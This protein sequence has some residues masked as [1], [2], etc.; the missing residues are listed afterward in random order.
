MS[1]TAVQLLQRTACPANLRPVKMAARLCE[2][3][4]AII[5][6]AY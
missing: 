4:A 3:A 1:A 6:G 2:L 5:A